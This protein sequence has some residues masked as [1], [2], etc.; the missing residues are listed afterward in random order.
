[1]LCST[2]WMLFYAEKHPA[3]IITRFVIPAV[4][5]EITNVLLLLA[6]VELPGLHK[7]IC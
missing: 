2:D 7:E 3:C 6:C 1:M 5:Y 4:F